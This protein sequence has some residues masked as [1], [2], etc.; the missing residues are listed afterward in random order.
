MFKRSKA[1]LRPEKIKAQ[2]IGYLK[3]NIF[4]GASFPSIS[5]LSDFKYITHLSLMHGFIELNR[6]KRT[7]CFI[8][9]H[10]LPPI[11]SQN[12]FIKKVPHT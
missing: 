2:G 6:I 7:K 3:A 8:S 12:E 4:P 11:R 5:T 1:D 9:I 10:N